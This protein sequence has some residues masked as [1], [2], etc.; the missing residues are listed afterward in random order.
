[1]PAALPPAGACAPCR[2]SGARPHMH[3]GL[4]G[5]E[6][7]E[8]ETAASS[9]GQQEGGWHGV[10]PPGKGGVERQTLH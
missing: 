2:G 7:G 8:G 10:A 3:A 4:D 9:G 6:T 1:M 5:G